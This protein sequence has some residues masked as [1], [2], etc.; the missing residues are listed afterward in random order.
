MSTILDAL[1]KSEQERK[2]NSL[3]TLSDMPPPQESSRLPLILL[4]VICALLVVLLLLVVAQWRS[5]HNSVNSEQSELNGRLS[6]A[7][8]TDESLPVDVNI[9]IPIDVVSFSD[10]PAQRFVMIEGK[11]VREKEFAQ[12]GVMVEEIQRDAVILNI[13][14][15]RVKRTP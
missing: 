7:A 1:K 11:V 6:V 14:G 3:P 9:V 10:E 15:Q 5:N 4:C 12:P 2:L 8:S 13:R